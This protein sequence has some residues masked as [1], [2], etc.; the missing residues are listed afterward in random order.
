[1]T[2][3]GMS[4]MVTDTWFVFSGSKLLEGSSRSDWMSKPIYNKKTGKQWLSL[5]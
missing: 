1:M 5:K 4:G 3:H 2:I